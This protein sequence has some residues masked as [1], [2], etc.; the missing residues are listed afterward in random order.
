MVILSEQHIATLKDAAKQ[1]TGAKRRAFQAQVAIDYLN[2]NP[3]LAERIFAWNRK[4][5]E[6]RHFATENVSRCIF[7]VYL[8]LCSETAL[9]SIG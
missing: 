3:R 5:T 2:S 9:M 6:P 4:T 7:V 1:L 8:T